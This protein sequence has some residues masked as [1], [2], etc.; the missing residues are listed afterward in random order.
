MKIVLVNSKNIKLVDLYLFM[1]ARLKYLGRNKNKHFIRYFIDE[2]HR[3]Y[4]ISWLE[5]VDEYTVEGIN[6]LDMACKR[7]I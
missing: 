2:C 6:V 3:C 5:D 1:T 7:V 4:G